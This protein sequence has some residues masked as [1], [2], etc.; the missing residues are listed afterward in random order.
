MSL[1]N[2]EA[3]NMQNSRKSDVGSNGWKKT[4]RAALVKVAPDVAAEERVD[5]WLSHTTQFG[6]V[7]RILNLR[8]YFNGDFYTGIA[9]FRPTRDDK[10]MEAVSEEAVKGA[11]ANL[12]K[13]AGE[14]ASG[15]RHRADLESRLRAEMAARHE[16]ESALGA[17]KKAREDQ[18]A[19][20]DDLRGMLK[21]LMAS[22]EPDPAPEKGP[23]VKK[24]T[25]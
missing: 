24:T 6:Q 2:I 15:N 19:E 5:F 18:Q 1:A 9:P 22:L 13:V 20:I 10:D 23:S 16:L 12:E 8:R 21:G 4:L 17:E 25:K 14:V 7:Q 3:G 11:L